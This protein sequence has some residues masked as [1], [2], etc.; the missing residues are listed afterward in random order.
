LLNSDQLIV[1]QLFVWP[2]IGELPIILLQSIDWQQFRLERSDAWGEATPHYQRIKIR[3][4]DMGRGYAFFRGIKIRWCNMGR[5]YASF[6][7]D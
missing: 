1:K 5:G 6:S 7:T 3:C 2:I 4:C